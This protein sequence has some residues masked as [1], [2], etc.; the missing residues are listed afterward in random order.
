MCLIQDHEPNNSIWK[1]D[2]VLQMTMFDCVY[3]PFHEGVWS[4]SIVEKKS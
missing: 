1:Y 3:A 2:V 4:E